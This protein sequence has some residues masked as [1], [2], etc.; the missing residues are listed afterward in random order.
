VDMDR[1][2][3]AATAAAAAAA[4]SGN[5]SND[6]AIML[7]GLP[8]AES[9]GAAGPRGF[10]ASRVHSLALSSR[11]ESGS[12]DGSGNGTAQLLA[13]YPV[14]Y[15]DVSDVS[16]GCCRCSRSHLYSWRAAFACQRL[17]KYA[18][19]AVPYN[20]A[21]SKP[22]H[23]SAR[24]CLPLLPL[25]FPACSGLLCPALACHAPAGAAT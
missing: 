19:V 11:G 24:S 8:L 21:S 18:Y 14:G 15:T 3:A 5:G 10:N 16:G 13:S 20:Y 1:L 12:L 4:A 23:M 25:A 22:G 6:L 17:G 7:P 9:S 2:L